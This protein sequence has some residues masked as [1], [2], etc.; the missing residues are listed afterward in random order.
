MNEATIARV[1]ALVLATA[2]H[3]PGDDPDA[4]L[5]SDADL[6]VLG[7]DPRRYGAYRRAIRQ[8]YAHLPDATYRL[9]RAAVLRAVLDRPVLFHTDALRSRYEPQARRNLAAE[10]AELQIP[11]GD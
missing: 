1:Q 3:Q 2:D 4:A 5:L 6:S 9:G 7:S 10:L 8:E 11:P